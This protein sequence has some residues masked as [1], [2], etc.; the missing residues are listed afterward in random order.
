MRI[1]EN[2]FN[3]T[4]GQWDWGVPIIFNLVPDAGL[5]IIGE[6]A[7]L[8]FDNVIET[9]TEEINSDDF[10]FPFALTKS[11]ADAL[12]PDAVVNP[13]KIP[14]SLKRYKDDQYLDTLFNANLIVT[15]TVKWDGES[16]S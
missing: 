12:F 10:D 11:E 5:S 2:N 14:Y 8:T 3:I 15:R 1:D 13:R 7:V 6:T 9:R 16:N 4:V